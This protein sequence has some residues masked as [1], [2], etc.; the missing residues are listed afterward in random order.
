V[1]RNGH[2]GND[3]KPRPVHD[4]RSGRLCPDVRIRAGKPLGALLLGLL[5]FFVFFAEPFNAASRID[6]LLFAGEKRMALGTNFHRDVFPGR[7]DF[8]FGATVARNL[9][10]RVGRMNVFFHGES[11]TSKYFMTAK[12]FGLVNSR[13]SDGFE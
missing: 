5:E 1:K 2:H 10:R 8:E 4:V 6:Q 7:T 13:L 12:F 3:S 11:L 9:R